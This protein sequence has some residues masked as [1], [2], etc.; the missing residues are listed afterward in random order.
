MR[1]NLWVSAMIKSMQDQTNTLVIVPG[2]ASFKDGINIPA[3]DDLDNDT[4]WA[5]QEFQKGEPYFYIEHIKK[6]IELIDSESL[7]IFSGGRTRKESGRE[8]SEARTYDEIAKTL[9]G[10]PADRVVLEEYARD[11]FQNLD[12]SICKF[13]QI[14]GYEPSRIRVVGWSFKSN[15]FEFHAQTLKVPVSNFEYIGVNDPVDKG[16]ALIGERRALDAFSQNPFGDS[17]QLA[18]KR[19]ERDPWND[20]EPTDY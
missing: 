4:H 5:L 18:Q 3:I 1:V 11:S 15:R 8:W 16:G 19:L 7:L 14:F 2:H 9:R 13:K 20:G 12:F 10:Y 17:G 6:A